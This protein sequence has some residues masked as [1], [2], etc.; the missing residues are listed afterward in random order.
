M[1]WGEALRHTITLSADPSSHVGAA[2][3]GMQFPASR[4]YLALLRLNDNFVARYTQKRAKFTSL[5]DPFE[6]APKRHTGTPMSKAA[7]DAVL[8]SHRAQPAVEQEATIV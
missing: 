3:N 7:L 8:A 6:V 2:V 1:T 4:E 5:P